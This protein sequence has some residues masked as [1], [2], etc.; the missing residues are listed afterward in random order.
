MKLLIRSALAITYAKM[1][2]RQPKEREF[3]ANKSLEEADHVI[4]DIETSLG[5]NKKANIESHSTRDALANAF[6]SKGFAFMAVGKYE[7]AIECFKESVRTRPGSLSNMLGLG[8][9][10]YRNNL[11]DEAMDTFRKAATH[12][13]LSGY[14]QYRLGNLYREIGK[15]DEAIDVLKRASHHAYARLTLGKIYLEDEEFEDA[16]E[17]FRQAVHLNSHL[18]EAWVNIAWTIIQMEEPSLFKE[19]LKAARRSLQQEKNEKQRWHRHAIVAICL[20]KLEKNE[21]ALIQASK[22]VELGPR[23]AQAY[24]YLAL[25]QHKLGQFEN[26]R[27]SIDKVI[28]LDK[29]GDWKLH[30]VQ[31]LNRLG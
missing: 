14:T 29:K 28:D 4:K 12:S 10:Y 25:I 20:S 7:Q 8:E 18:S 5:K 2:E 13:P 11:K 17:E 16:L 26:A 21:L 6:A 24:Y 23:Q 1:A 9:A 15:R 27:Q 30:A 31:L 3:L 22:A 19:A